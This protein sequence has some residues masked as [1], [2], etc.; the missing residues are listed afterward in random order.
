MKRMRACSALPCTVRLFNQLDQCNASMRVCDPAVWLS[1]CTC[2]SIFFSFPFFFVRVAE[3]NTSD[4][5]ERR[6]GKSGTV[7]N[8]LRFTS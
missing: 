5:T 2:H 1:R 8:H 7:S 6:S 3:L 4:L